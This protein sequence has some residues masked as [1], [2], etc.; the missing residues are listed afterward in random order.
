MDVP[1][2]I[3]G[4]GTL[5]ESLAKSSEFEM[6]EGKNQYFC[7]HCNKLVDAK[8]RTCFKRLPAILIFS[9]LRFDYDMQSNERVKMSS[10][11]KF[12]EVLDMKPFCDETLADTGEDCYTFDLFAV[13]W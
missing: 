10:V 11:M 3:K 1:V 6:L 5:E 7:G 2:V 9:L 8:R 4:F 12:P 13:V